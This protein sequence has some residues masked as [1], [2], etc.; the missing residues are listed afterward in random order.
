MRHGST[1]FRDIV[2]DGSPNSSGNSTQQTEHALPHNHTTNPRR[3]VLA[4]VLER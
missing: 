2:A 3:R 1:T 4:Y